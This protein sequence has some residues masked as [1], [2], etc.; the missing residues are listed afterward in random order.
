[1]SSWEE[2]LEAVQA[3]LTGQ[4]EGGDLLRECWAA[5]SPDDHAQRCVLAHYLADLEPA[6]EDEI[7]WDEIALAEFPAV[8]DADLAPVGIVSAAGLAPSLYLNLADGY[9]RRGDP[10]AAEVQYQRGVDSLPL[11]ADDGYGSMIRDGYARLRD[12]LDTGTGTTGR[13]PPATT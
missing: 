9:L 12:Q 4:P 1:M 13:L 11:L 2:V 10:A 6:L 7:A 8:A 5:T 3:A